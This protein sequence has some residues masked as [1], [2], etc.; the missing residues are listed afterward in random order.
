MQQ[1]GRQPEQQQVGQLTPL[2]QRLEAF[3]QQND[4]NNRQGVMERNQ[5]GRFT[6]V[7]QQANNNRNEIANL[8]NLPNQGQ[9]G[10]L[11]NQGQQGNLP[12]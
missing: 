12:N 5:Q 10:N 8:G 11:P 4:R 1:I 6:R 9:Q 2:Q 7:T 3:I